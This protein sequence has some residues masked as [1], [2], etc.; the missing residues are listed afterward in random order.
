[1]VGDFIRI[2]SEV[3]L[4][5]NVASNTA[6]SVDAP[7]NASISDSTHHAV[8]PEF[9][10]LRVTSANST[11][12]VVNRPPNYTVNSSVFASLQKVVHG[13]VNFYNAGSGKLYLKDSNSSNSNFQ[14]RV[15]NSTNFAYLVGDKTDSLAKVVSID[16]IEFTEF[17]P[18]I[19]VLQIPSTTV[20]FS[21]TFT[22]KSSGTGSSSYSLSGSN[23]VG[24][25]E[26][27]VIK[28][29]TNE[30]S[31]S[32]INK[33]FTATLGISSAFGDTTPVIDINPSSVIVKKYNVNNSKANENTRYGNAL[34]KYISK[35]LELVE[36]LEAE[37]VKVYI[38][39]YKPSGTNIDVYAKILSSDDTEAFNHKD[40][41]ELEQVT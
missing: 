2:G 38:K 11:A 31:G 40:W 20:N 23:E 1:V 41:Y 35:R 4:V 32:T 33:S 12:L 18:F 10:V 25:N 3:R 16:D 36:E 14:V 27:V 6:L 34:C 24:L 37:D 39:A 26:T 22:R 28:S 8:D 9:D 29:K 19:N 13:V 21:A 5:T 7:F 30:I 15:S 17:T